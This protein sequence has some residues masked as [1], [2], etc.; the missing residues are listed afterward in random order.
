MY[1]H[2]GCDLQ[3][4]VG[5]LQA[6]LRLGLQ[7]PPLAQAAMSALETWELEQPQAIQAVAPHVVP[8]LD[9]YLTDIQDVA[10]PAEA[11]P[12]GGQL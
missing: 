5:P 11:A 7:Y 10:A 2:L 1:H 4:L 8:L 9:P 6:A 3:E 12:T